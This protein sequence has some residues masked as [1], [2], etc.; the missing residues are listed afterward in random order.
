MRDP[1]ST[2]F[3]W[4]YTIGKEDVWKR[5]GILNMR[6][7]IPKIGRINTLRLTYPTNN[8]LK[9]RFKVLKSSTML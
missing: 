2:E 6:D 1:T 8:M 3:P 5:W 7:Y 4:R 9:D